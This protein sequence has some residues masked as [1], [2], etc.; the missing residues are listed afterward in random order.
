VLVG[1]GR[2]WPPARWSILRRSVLL[3]LNIAAICLIPTTLA[4]LRNVS[5]VE[6]RSYDD[7]YSTGF[8]AG[9]VDVQQSRSAIQNQA[10][11]YSSGHWVSDIYPYDA[12]GRPLVGVQLFDQLGKPIDVVP[13]PECPDQG[14]GDA[15][16]PPQTW[17]V[18]SGGGTDG[19]CV[20]YN[21]VDN[22]AR[23][24]Y[25]WVNGATR[26]DNV[27]P[28]ATRLQQTFGARAD[29]FSSSTPPSI[30]PFPMASVPPVSLPGIEPSAQRPAVTAARRPR[31]R[32]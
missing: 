1:L 29:A 2:I 11:V 30:G 15:T 25:S 23:V 5:E 20:D 22:P 19:T 28:L 8:R 4:M 26:V 16:A 24:P 18:V 31:R 21:G 27:F 12:S 6:S 14:A 9:Q 3:V 13:A 17:S 7:G 32:R 10:G